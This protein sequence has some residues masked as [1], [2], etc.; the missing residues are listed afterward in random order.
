M[1]IRVALAGAGA[2][3]IKHLDGLKN[4]DD[5]EVVS[6]IGRDLDKTREVAGK[7]GINHL[8]CYLIVG[9][10]GETP[11]DYAALAPL[12]AE[13]AAAGSIGVG[14]RGIAHATLSVNPLVPKPFTPMQWAPMAGEAAIEAAYARVRE[15]V[16]PLRGFRVDILKISLVVICAPRALTFF[17]STSI[18]VNICW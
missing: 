10:P 11:E 3:G 12:L 1:T 2:F 18:A 8:K 15:T 5:V 17:T 14:K 4:I 9:W 6:V 16:K 7:Y 13:V